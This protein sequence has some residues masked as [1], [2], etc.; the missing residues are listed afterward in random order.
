MC[1]W[2]FFFVAKS[3]HFNAFYLSKKCLTLSF[4]SFYYL[5]E[6]IIKCLLFLICAHGNFFIAP[7]KGNLLR[8][9]LKINTHIHTSIS[10]NTY[11]VWTDNSI[12]LQLPTFYANRTRFTLK[13]WRVNKKNKMDPIYTVYFQVK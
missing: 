9:C 11:T 3:V 4:S 2:V 12:E 7:I 6:T 10:V 13:Q 5:R 1:V 8:F